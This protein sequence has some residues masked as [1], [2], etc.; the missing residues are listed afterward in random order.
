LPRAH[1]TAHTWFCCR[2]A[3]RATFCVTADTYLTF[4]YLRSLRFAY[5]HRNTALHLP[6]A[7]FVPLFTTHP[8]A[9]H[10]FTLPFDVTVERC[11]FILFAFTCAGSDVTADSRHTCLPTRFPCPTLRVCTC[12][13][14][15]IPVLHHVYCTVRSTFTAVA[16]AGYCH[17]LLRSTVYPPVPFC[18]GDATRLP[19]RC[20]HRCH[21]WIHVRCTTL[22]IARSCSRLPDLPDYRCRAH[23]Y[24]PTVAAHVL[25]ICYLYRCRLL[26][27]MPVTHAHLRYPIVRA[28]A[29]A[30]RGCCHLRLDYARLYT[31]V[32]DALRST[33]HLLLVSPAAYVTYCTHRCRRYN[34][35]PLRY[36]C[37]LRVR[38]LFLCTTHVARPAFCGYLR[39]RL[40]VTTHGI[41]FTLPAHTL[42]VFLGYGCYSRLCSV[43]MPLLR[44]YVL[45]RC[46]RVYLRLTVTL[47]GLF[48]PAVT[49]RFLPVCLRCS[50]PAVSTLLPARIRYVRTLPRCVHARLALLVVARR[51]MTLL[52]FVTYLFAAVCARSFTWFGLRWLPYCTRLRIH[53]VLPLRAFCGLVYRIYRGCYLYGCRC[54]HVCFTNCLAVSAVCDVRLHA[55]TPTVSAQCATRS[56]TFRLYTGCLVCGL[57]PPRVPTRCGCGYYH[58][59]LPQLVHWIRFNLL[60]IA[61][62]VFLLFITTRSFTLR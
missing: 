9:D 24:L 21:A 3:P 40:L 47:R 49:A 58:V 59:S 8:H 16:F 14:F 61:Y 38:A 56:A 6:R 43:T 37:D 5:V 7:T 12:T 48:W 27:F 1:Y 10:G 23:C 31:D 39:C 11:W 17:F 22:Q 29:T 62:A 50:L 25:H 2:I 32:C 30:C 54:L 19:L 41:L 15:L 46:Y 33:C 60:R 53:C 18:L 4:S 20:V 13:D 55:F 35:Y 51:L 34:Y 36:R 28:F 57:L 26:D 45:T 42:H 44:D 52:P